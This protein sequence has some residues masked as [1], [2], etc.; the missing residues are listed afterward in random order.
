MEITRDDLRLL[1]HFSWALGNSPI[2]IHAQLVRVHGDGIC[3]LQTVRNWT[4]RFERGIFEL[5]DTERSGRPP[6]TDL[7]LK[8]QEALDESPFMSAHALAKELEEDR[9]TIRRVLKN[10]LGLTKLSL[11]WVP[12]KLTPEL[13]DARSKCA[14]D[15]FGTIS[16]MGPIQ[17]NHVVTG[18]QSWVFLRNEQTHIWAKRSSSTPVRVKR[19]Q[20]EYKVMLTVMFSRKGV[21]LIDFL[22]DGQK[23]NSTHMTTVV[24]PA[25]VTK[26]KETS[27]KKGAHGWLIH[28]DNSRVHNS[29]ET[30]QFIS[31]EGFIRLPH[32]PYSPDLAPSDFSLFGYLKAHLRSVECDDPDGLKCEITS[33]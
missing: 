26:I 24:L 25:L 31:G 17:R 18:D 15:L 7:A 10:T 21:L 8:V 30:T 2:D 27:P 28:L 16:S 5:T 23:F 12:H 20:G 29:M 6:R 22:P 13:M 14:A 32:P 19:T 33:F 4:N 11:R 9:R 3:S 1:I